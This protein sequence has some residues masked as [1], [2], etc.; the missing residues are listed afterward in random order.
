MNPFKEKAKKPEEYL[1]GLKDLYVTQYDKNV[2]DPYTKTRIILACGSEFESNWYSHQMQR[3]VSDNGL[4]QSLAL[5][6]F[7]E[8]QQQQSLATLKPADESVLETTI[9]YEQLAV[10]L[11]AELA[12]R[13]CNKNVKNALDFALLEDFDHLYRYANL[14]DTDYDIHAETLVGRYT[15][16]TPARPTIAHHRHPVD[17]VK[18][19]IEPSKNNMQTVLN[20]MIITA[21]EQQTMNFYMNVGATYQ[22][23]AGRKL[24]QEICLVEE[25]HV[26]Q[27][28][29]LIDT[30][31]D[32]FEGLLLHEYCEC[33]LYWS[34]LQTETDTKIK[35]IWEYFLEQEISHLHL[36][37]AILKKHA[38]KDYQQVIPDANFPDP[39][40][41]HENIDY[42]RDVLKNTVSLTGKLTDY[43][44]INSLETDDRFFAYNKRFNSPIENN[45]S[46]TVIDTHIKKQG[47]D[48]RFETQPNPIKQLTDNT[49]D[50]VKI[51]V[52]KNEVKCEGFKGIKCKCCKSGSA[53][54]RKS[55]KCK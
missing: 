42:V 20:T 8:K 22:N 3:K 23:D 28:G 50:N 32:L 5:S 30:S 40:C 15:E 38:K 48:Y 39:I 16:I 51:G 49:S 14:L 47:K 7:I 29:S 9:S 6:R 10:D 13:E 26:T 45:P 52:C 35:R 4:R 31:K 1:E 34:N 55:N 43:K 46:H 11:T 17:N 25:E 41:L 37:N 36:A 33:Y 21:A 44:D 54:K 2:V 24:Y 18:K 27:Y 53:C 12:K 19:P